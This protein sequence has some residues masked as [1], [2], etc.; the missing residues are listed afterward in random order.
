MQLIVQIVLEELKDLGAHIYKVA[1][2]GS[3]YIKFADERLRSLRIGD[4]DGRENYKY[5]W[6]LRADIEKAYEEMDNGVRRFYYSYGEVTEFIERIR[7]YWRT[8]LK[9]QELM[10]FPEECE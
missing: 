2:T 1:K 8:I 5:K 3:V 10:A 9:N 4:H 6:N 7:Q